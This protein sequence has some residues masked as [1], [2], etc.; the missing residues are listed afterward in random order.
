MDRI[1][2][3][4]DMN[5]QALFYTEYQHVLI[6]MISLQNRIS[7]VFEPVFTKNNTVYETVPTKNILVFD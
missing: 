4:H 3:R 7:V 5:T 2:I 1:N 6:I